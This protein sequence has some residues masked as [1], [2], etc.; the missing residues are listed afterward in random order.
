MSLLQ[1]F[2][3]TPSTL[4]LYEDADVT[5]TEEHLFQ[6]RGELTGWR[7]SFAGTGFQY[8]DGDLAG[9]LIT[10]YELAGPDGAAYFRISGL[11]VA[12]LDLLSGNVSGL[13]QFA[14]A[15]AD[16]VIGS[17][18]DDTLN[19]LEGADLVMDEAGNDLLSAVD[20]AADTLA[21]GSGDDRYKIDPKDSIQEAPGAGIDSI[22]LVTVFAY[23]P[24]EFLGTYVMPDHVE[25]LTTSANG[26]RVV[27]NAQANR[28]EDWGSSQNTRLE[29]MDGNDT[30]IG[31]FDRIVLAGGNG[32][33]TY[34]LS[35]SSGMAGPILFEEAGGGY[36][37]V[38]SGN[39]STVQLSDHIEKLVLSPSAT[40]AIGNG[41]NNLI[42]R[43]GDTWSHLDGGGGADT[44]IGG[45]GNDT[46]VVDDARDV[47]VLGGGVDELIVR[48]SGLTIA[49]GIRTMRME[50]AANLA[51]GSAAADH[52]IGNIEHESTIHGGDGNDTLKAGAYEFSVV[53]RASLH[54]DRGDDWLYVG[55]GAGLVDGGSGWDTATIPSGPY[56]VTREGSDVLVRSASL[57]DGG[58]V[59][60]RGVEELI[61][62]GSFGVE[63]IVL[64]A[65]LVQGGV[66]IGGEAAAGATVQSAQALTD[67]DGLDTLQYQWFRSDAPLAGATAASYLLT[68]QDIGSDLRLRVQFADAAGNLETAWSNIL[69][70]ATQLSAGAGNDQLQGGHAAETIAAQ[71][72][73][74]SIWG[75]GGDD[76]VLGGEGVDTS[77]YGGQRSEYALARQAGTTFVRDGFALRDGADQL[78]QVEVLRFEDRTVDLRAHALAATI[79]AS[80][81]KSIE[82]LYVGFFDRIPEAGG[83][84]YWIEQRQ[85]GKELISIAQEFFEAG[86]AFKIFDTSSWIP[87]ADN[88]RAVYSNVLQRPTDGPDAPGDAEIQYWLDWL[89]DNNPFDLNFRTQ[90]SNFG[91]MVVQMLHDVHAGFEG[92]ERYGYV[93]ALLNNKAALANY[94]AIEQGLG[95]ITPADSITYGQKLADLVVPEGITAAIEFIG[96][97]PVTVPPG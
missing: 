5:A 96:V 3:P 16:T 24:Q 44:L 60:L 93:P 53:G 34:E 19:G 56:N 21:G 6:L 28:L 46:F 83:L 20:A 40:T 94:Y 13:E 91:P 95:S 10:G 38:Y 90:Y 35:S 92:H 18:N 88:V 9:G 77:F 64:N 86:R 29:G 49:P 54:G 82:E 41:Q 57:V 43:E 45:P 55:A 14:L 72:G 85:M 7:L 47:I 4:S 74:D 52:I 69:K 59:V 2:R 8:E 63:R 70:T 81:L 15:G 48:A 50:G 23:D 58:P 36:D 79:S 51:Y 32:D 37:T 71:A 78:Q 30:L 42:V 11:S 84:V 80:D 33:D 12:V 65:H 68:Q 73:N 17:A 75:G 89:T 31:S 39:V 87:V 76:T 25:N 66:G 67:P 27:G 97:N 1:V 22:E 61:V 62:P 26:W